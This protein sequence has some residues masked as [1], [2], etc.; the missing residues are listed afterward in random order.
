MNGQLPVFLRIFLQFCGPANAEM[1]MSAVH[2][3]HR[4]HALDASTF[5]HPQ[6]DAG[7][8]ER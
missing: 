2:E 6:L 1:N 8:S 7:S 3:G 5:V 4:H